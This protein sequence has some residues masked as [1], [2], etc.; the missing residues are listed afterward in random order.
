MEIRDSR[1]YRQQFPTFEAYCR[2]RWGIGLRYSNR[3]LAAAEV[4]HTLGP[5]GPIPQTET[6]A[7]PLTRLEPEVQ[8]EVWQAVI[9][10]TPH[11]QITAKVVEEKAKA[12][13]VLNEAVK[14][15]KEE[16]K[17]EPAVIQ[18][19]IIPEPVKPKDAVIAAVTERIKLRLKRTVE[20]I[21]EIGREL[22]AVK[23]ELPHGQ[24]L[25]W[26]AAEFE[27]SERTA[28]NFMD[29]SSK[30]G[31][32][33]ATVA[34]LQPKIL[35]ALSAPSTPDSVIDKAI[36]KAESGEKV[37]VSDV[38][39]WKALG[40]E[41]FVEY[42]E[43]ELNFGSAYLYRLADAAEISLQ[44][45][46]SPIGE[47]QPPE[48]QLRPLAQVPEEERKAIW[49]EATR[50]AEEE[51]AKLT[52]QRVQEAVAEWKQRSQESQQESNERRLKISELETQIDLLKGAR[53]SRNSR[54]LLLS[55]IKN[56]SG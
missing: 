31:D 30:F 50:K 56:Y 35:Y 9:A 43:K 8:Q 18:Q 23:T 20:D 13:E 2:E 5:I 53:E 41:S 15:I 37:T 17:P 7:R 25:P 39:D 26:I 40:Y 12:A 24:F 29:V 22:T 34:N 54:L 32:K 3:L 19:P 45:G 6:Q 11:E 38:K 14:A 4:V 46:F 27:M 16:L 21:I 52:A 42:G 36:E 49:D 51:H 55:R 10:E 47:K 44:I 1:L 33:L 48:S 28:Y